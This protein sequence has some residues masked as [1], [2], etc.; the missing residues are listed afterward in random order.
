[1]FIEREIFAK[2][3]QWKNST[4]RLPLI[5]QGARQTGKTFAMKE[6][7]KRNFKWTA[8]FNFDET[9]DL[10]KEFE[11]TK[12]PQRLIERLSFYTN[13]PID[14]QNTLI[15]FDEIQECNKALNSLKYFAE[16]APN[17]CIVCA[18]SLL[19]VSLSKGDSFPVGKVNFMHLYPVT[20][21]EFFAKYSKDLYSYAENISAVENMP[22][23]IFSKFK[24]AYQKYQI[25]G[26]MPAAISEL[27]EKS[28][29][30][31]VEEKLQDILNSY[32][33]DFAKHIQTA[34]IA[35][36]LAI[37]NS[38]PSQLSKENRKFIYKL[39]KPGARAKE[40]EDAL[41]WL[42]HSGLIY[43]IFCIS[44]PVLPLSAYDDLTAFKIYLSDIGLLR[45]LAK[46]PSEAVLLNNNLFIEFKGALAE[47]FVL[48]SLVNHF[49]VK[50]R[51]WVSQG[52]AEVDFILQ[53]GVDIIPIEVKSAANTA[54]KSL[55]QYDK[56]YSPQI[57]IRYSLN[58]FKKDGNLLN[59]PIFFADWTKKI[60]GLI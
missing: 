7:G 58:N 29:I 5:L 6:F 26:G 22:Q 51:Y 38:I 59:I 1:M 8:Y 35:R 13:V 41:L 57:R 31:T 18:G 40:Y 28:G 49:D 24:D 2:L 33:L 17:F 23:I 19:G 47:N 20:F 14:P 10:K 44:K 37:W 53:N 43:R 50:P 25:S 42:E 9:E 16:N 21:K 60:L 46:L 12:D 11:E 56:E 48:Q 30:S 45:K 54:S 55:A 27:L 3:E 4:N 15:I 52:K 39:I 32:S 34:D 36:I